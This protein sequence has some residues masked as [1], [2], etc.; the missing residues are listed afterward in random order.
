[1]SRNSNSRLRGQSLVEFALV[2]PVLLLLL[3]GAIDLGR[4]YFSAITLENAVKEGA[5][6]GARDPECATD[7][8]AG[9][10]DPGNVEARVEVEMDGLVLSG[11]EVKC[12]NAGTTDFSGPGKLLADCDDGDLYLVRAQLP[13]SLVTPI[14]SFLAGSPITISSDATAVVVTSFSQ[15]GGQVGFPSATP[16]PTPS[17]GLC[18][19]PDFTLGPTK[20]QGR[21]RCLVG[22]RRLRGEQHHH[23]RPA[24]Q[25]HLAGRA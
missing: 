4:A 12:F 15:V 22:Q 7:A 5:F 13:F 16:L 25:G 24:E 14:I 18:T 23:G 19:V 17:P 21:G 10:E 3:A 6:W 1:M 20:N 2:L 9:C 8:T 11:F